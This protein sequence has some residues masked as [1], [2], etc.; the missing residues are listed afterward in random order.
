MPLPG[1]AHQLGEVVVG[2]DQVADTLRSVEMMSVVGISTLAAV[3]DDVVECRRPWSSSRRRPARPSRRRMSKTT[4]APSVGHLDHLVRVAFLDLNG[5]V[6]APISLARSRASS[7]GST[8]IMSVGVIA[9]RHWMPMCPRP[10]APITTAFVPSVQFRDRLPDRVVGGQARVGEGRDV[11][12]FQDRVELD[13]AP[14]RW[15]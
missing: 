6:G 2:P 13:H 4:S 14:A 1:Q 10:P 8:T 11:L 15:S 5:L 7:L 9:L 3:A 12:R